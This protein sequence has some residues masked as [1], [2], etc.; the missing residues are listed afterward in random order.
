MEALGRHMGHWEN[1]K[2]IRQ[3]LRAFGRHMGHRADIVDIGQKL[4]GMGRHW[5]PPYFAI[6]IRLSVFFIQYKTFR[7]H[8]QD[9]AFWFS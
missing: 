6:R 3:K 7:F 1:I 5:S 9:K 4:G 2:N 8:I